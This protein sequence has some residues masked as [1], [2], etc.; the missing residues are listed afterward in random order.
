[1]ALRLSCPSC[2][3]QIELITRSPQIVV[4]PA[5]N[6]TSEL[7]NSAFK[8]LGKFALLTESL[9]R[10]NLGKEFKYD[11]KTYLPVGR[12]RYDYGKGYW[13]EWYVRC[14]NN[15]YSWISED[16]GDIVI[17]TLVEPT[18]KEIPGYYNIQ[19][20]TF[21]K[22]GLNKYLVAEKGRC[23]MV[24]CEGELPFKIIPGDQY[25]YVD[26]L[27]IG[28][29]SYSIE[30]DNGKIVCYSGKWIDPFEIVD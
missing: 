27:G 30:Y 3:N 29:L 12:V 21:L 2:G 13:D 14:D 4:C 1:M 25:D 24:G 28:A 23:K 10:L 7:E 20:D 16:E 17:E 19:L 8:L 18:P 22:I 5:C 26:L 11:N 9:S 6:S 15:T